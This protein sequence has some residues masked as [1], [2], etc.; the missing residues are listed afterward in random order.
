MRNYD[1]LCDMILEPEKFAEYDYNRYA[2]CF[3]DE[4]T[5][6]IFQ[7]AKMIK[8]YVLTDIEVR[9]FEPASSY[10]MGVEISLVGYKDEKFEVKNRTF[11]IPANPILK[12]SYHQHRKEIIE[13][14][15]SILKDNG[16]FASIDEK[17]PDQINLEIL[18]DDNSAH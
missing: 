8:G 12:E 13:N 16:Y 7:M 9:H 15:V 14:S 18:I 1:K 6:V 3:V 5:E 4:L 17:N 10:Y 11:Y 2:T